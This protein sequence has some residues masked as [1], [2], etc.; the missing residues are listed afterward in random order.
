MSNPVH[1]VNLRPFSLICKAHQNAVSAKAVQQCPD[2]YRLLA[3]AR[4]R[5]PLIIHEI[6]PE[7][8]IT[9]QRL[10]EVDDEA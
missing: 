4:D 9:S 2:C 1:G 3:E 8:G 7:T 10:G 6:D 5:H